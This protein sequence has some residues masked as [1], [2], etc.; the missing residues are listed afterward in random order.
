MKATQQ[1]ARTRPAVLALGT[2]LIAGPILARALAGTGTLDSDVWFLL[3]TG[4][5]IARNGIPHA[6]PFSIWPGQGIVVQQW[7]HDLWLWAW[8][9]A[10]GYAAVAV[11]PCVPAGLLF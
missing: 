3:A 8:Y 7:L 2:L 9:T 4:R 6:N 10:G 5:E 1:G 11:S